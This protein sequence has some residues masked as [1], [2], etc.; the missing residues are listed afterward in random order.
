M[1]P[2]VIDRIEV[3]HGF[4]TQW[5]WDDSGYRMKRLPLLLLSCFSPGADTLGQLHAGT[6]RTQLSPTVA[7]RY[8]CPWHRYAAGNMHYAPAHLLPYDTC[9]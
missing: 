4:R 2:I 1:L 8:S 3:S 6:K 5:P 9:S 7:Y